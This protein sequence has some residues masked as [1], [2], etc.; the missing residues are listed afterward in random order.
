MI[1][2]EIQSSSLLNP[3]DD[4]VIQDQFAES[5]EVVCIEDVNQNYDPACTYYGYEGFGFLSC[6][7]CKPG[8]AIQ[9]LQDSSSQ[10]V[11]MNTKTEV[12][13]TT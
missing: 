6:L 11:S 5:P 4:V 12:C 8:F 2:L 1:S 3:N 13:D 9:F 10:C 7:L